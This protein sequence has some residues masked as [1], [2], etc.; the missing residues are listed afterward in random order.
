MRTETIA[1]PDISWV[2]NPWQAIALLAVVALAETRKTLKH[3]IQPNVGSS[4]KD[5]LNRS[6]ATQVEQGERLAKLEA[7]AEQR[8]AR[9]MWHR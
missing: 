7:A 1:L 4:L 5:S 8:G 6:E 2:V 3:E 9:R